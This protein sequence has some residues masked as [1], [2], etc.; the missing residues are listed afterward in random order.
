MGDMTLYVYCKLALFDFGIFPKQL[1]LLLEKYLLDNHL[2]T[3]NYKALLKQQKTQLT[4]SAKPSIP[5][6]PTGSSDSH[7]R[8]QSEIFGAQ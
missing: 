1:S 6:N 2:H 8:N 5:G 4:S 3:A 7:S